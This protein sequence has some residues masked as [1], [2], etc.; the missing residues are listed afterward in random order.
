MQRVLTILCLLFLAG[1]QSGC[2]TS[3]REVGVFIINVWD[4][5]SLPHEFKKLA[6][7]ARYC[8]SEGR[9]RSS[10]MMGEALRNCEERGV[11]KRSSKTIVLKVFFQNG[12]LLGETLNVV[13]RNQMKV[14]FGSEIAIHNLSSGSGVVIPVGRYTLRSSEWVDQRM[15]AHFIIE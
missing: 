2:V 9:C 10:A 6:E 5:T 8:E 11:C 7:D 1:V 14:P 3:P 4:F 12:P 15:H 13:G